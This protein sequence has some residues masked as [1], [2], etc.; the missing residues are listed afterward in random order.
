MD[1][2]REHLLEA[3]QRQRS[4][5]A[6][7]RITGTPSE[8]GEGLVRLAELHGQLD[9]HAESRERFQ[10]ALAQFGAA[11]DTLGEARA[12]FGLGV[13]AANQE[14]HR[15]SVEHMAR[16]A[17]LYNQRKDSRGEALCRACI[18]ESLRALGHSDGAAEKYQEALILF[19]QLK[20]SERV[21]ALL[22]DLGDLKMEAGDFR[23]A[24]K[25]FEEA[26]PLASSA[27]EAG[28]VALCQ[29]LIGECE[30]LMKNHA[31]ARPH[32][33]AA[34]EGFRRVGD[35]VYEARARWDASLASYFL[36]DVAGARAQLETTLPLY[37]AHGTP[38]QVEK[39]KTVL[40]HL[41][42]QQQQGGGGPKGT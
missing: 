1:G 11:Q 17:Y 40:A 19:R 39:A 35:P 29:L 20:D 41:V 18:G 37:E 25:R 6:T 21:A 42:Q 10:E 2:E 5:L 30:G 16:A 38:E 26:L 33:M 7:L 12:H 31:E 32:L 34:A 23:A 36:G 3:L 22:I 14:E 15:A 27:G 28:Q 13:A 8:V 9:E 4:A 24:R